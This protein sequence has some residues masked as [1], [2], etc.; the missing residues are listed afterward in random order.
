MKSSY[1]LNKVFLSFATK[2]FNKLK[3]LSLPTVGF[4]QLNRVNVTLNQEILFTDIEAGKLQ[5]FG[6]LSDINGEEVS[7]DF[8]ISD[9]GSQQYATS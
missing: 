8:T 3:I 6:N 5:A 7:F 2:A 9:T 4:L 1:I